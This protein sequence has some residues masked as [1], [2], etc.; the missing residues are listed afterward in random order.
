MPIFAVVFAASISHAAASD[1]WEEVRTP[2]LHAYTHLVTD[3]RRALN[4]GQN[5][6]A[7]SSSAEAIAILPAMSAAHVIHARALSALERDEEAHVEVRDLLA[8][9]SAAFQD[10][11]DALVAARVCAE[12]ADYALAATI[13]ESAVDREGPGAARA[14]LYIFLADMIQSRGD[15]HLRD[16]I[17][18]YRIGLRATPTDPR[19]RVGLALALRRAGERA[20]AQAALGSML[21]MGGRVG[22][23]FAALRSI[24]PAT[25]I[26]AREGVALEAMNDLVGAREA[27]TRAG[28]EGPWRAFA[29]R[30]LSE[31]GTTTTPASSGASTRPHTAQPPPRRVGP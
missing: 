4:T 27:W 24:L 19:A 1:F 10:T 15:G 11:Q 23:T 2:G 25:E 12:T 26:A 8:R 6:V 21:A 7:L 14:T 29:E 3:A 18:A 5:Q 20:E 28:G 9:D 13:L 31:V 30:A 22:Q 16:A 17:S